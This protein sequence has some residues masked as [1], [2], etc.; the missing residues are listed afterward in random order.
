MDYWGPYPDGAPSG[1]QA[2]EMAC[3]DIL[4]LLL[5]IAPNDVQLADGS[6][7]PG[8]IP[9]IQNLGDRLQRA[10][11]WDIHN[12][13]ATEAMKRLATEAMARRH[14]QALQGATSHGASEA[15]PTLVR[16]PGEIDADREARCIAALQTLPRG[17]EHSG[18]ALPRRAWTVLAENLPR[19]SLR[20][21][22]LRHPDIFRVDGAPAQWT[23]QVIAAGQEG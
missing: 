9:R 6:W 16:V 15:R 10:V 14:A 11:R 7:H 2:T 12:E 1:K 19:G 17:T 23:F 8:A 4:M 18:N 21:L 5:A 20:P 13:L 3:K 22:L